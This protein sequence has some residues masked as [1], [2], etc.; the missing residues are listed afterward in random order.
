METLSKCGENELW[1]FIEYVAILFDIWV[2][3]VHAYGMLFQ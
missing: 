1:Q 3:G 2:N